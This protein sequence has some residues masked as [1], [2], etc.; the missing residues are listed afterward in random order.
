MSYRISIDRAFV[1]LAVLSL[2]AY[3]VVLVDTAWIGDDAYITFRTVENAIHGFGLCWNVDDRVHVYTHPLWMLL[4]IVARSVVGDM[5][6]AGL[7]LGFVLSVVAVVLA[8]FRVASGAV[9]GALL[10]AYLVS[11]RGFVDYSTSGLENPM[12]HLCLV[13]IV[14][15]LVRRERDVEL[16]GRFGGLLPPAVLSGALLLNRLDML[17]LVAPLLT[18]VAVRGGVLRAMQAF[19]LGW[20]PVFVWFAF[21]TFYYG[22]PLP[23]TAAAKVFGLGI[24]SEDLVVQGWWYLHWSAWSD[25]VS[26]APLVL[27]PI[28]VLRTALPM[29][30][31]EALAVLGGVLLHGAY[32]IRVGG[33]FMGGRFW[34]APMLYAALVCASARVGWTPRFAGAAFAVLLGV[35]FVGRPSNLAG[36]FTWGEHAAHEVVHGIADERRAYADRYNVHSANFDPPV[37]GALPEGVAATRDEPHFAPCAAAGGVGFEGGASVHY[38]DLWIIDPLL[39][40]LPNATPGKWRIGHVIRRVPEGYWESLVSGENRIHHAGLARYYNN[41]QSAIRGPL[42]SVARMSAVWRLMVGADDSGLREFVA[43]DYYEPPRV[44][45]SRDVLEREVATG[46]PWYRSPSVIVYDGGVEV[47]LGAV[48]RDCKAVTLAVDELDAVRIT[49]RL[50]GQTVGEVVIANPH[51]GS[52]LQRSRAALPEGAQGGFDA[53]WIDCVATQDFVCAVGG[54]GIVRD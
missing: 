27:L 8:V 37:Y 6:W 31:L 16:G 41:L 35:G 5:Y 9:T 42:W 1:G 7:A 47:S 48:V 11:A 30:R 23:V 45:R 17:L 50:E 53:L 39:A 13:L 28:V 46:Q 32:V 38:V 15:W 36:V 12:S 19:L 33:D 10:A 43:D 26:L 14:A 34:V 21:A 3:V 20:L 18:V 54:L 24:P 4:L 25:P 49:F 2:A 40:R 52:G 22:S 51:A 44:A 29:A